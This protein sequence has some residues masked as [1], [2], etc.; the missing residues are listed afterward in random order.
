LAVG[1]WIFANS[2]TP[3]LTVFVVFMIERFRHI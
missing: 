2:N 3:R 1:Y